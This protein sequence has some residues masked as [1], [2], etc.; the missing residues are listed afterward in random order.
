MF[1]CEK[2]TCGYCKKNQICKKKSAIEYRKV[3]K[4]QKK[5]YFCAEVNGLCRL[6]DCK[7]FNTCN[8]K[9]KKDYLAWKSAYLND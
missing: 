4:N 7:K 1:N 8:A 6:K 3:R 2:G 9:A 5:E